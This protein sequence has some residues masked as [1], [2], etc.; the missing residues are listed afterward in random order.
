[1]RE[2]MGD[3]QALR[4]VAG[5]FGWDETQIQKIMAQKSMQMVNALASLPSFESFGNV[6]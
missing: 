2:L 3:E 4:E 5:V 6:Q 1:M